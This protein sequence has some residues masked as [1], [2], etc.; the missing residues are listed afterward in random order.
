VD[1][2]IAILKER[3]C[4]L[5]HLARQRVGDASARDPEVDAAA[6]DGLIA[7]E[8]GGVRDR[9]FGPPA[10]AGMDAAFTIGTRPLVSRP[11]AGAPLRSNT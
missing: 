6:A 5:A 8:E 10:G 1:D 9:E 2:D 4:Q 7:V 11:L 3:D